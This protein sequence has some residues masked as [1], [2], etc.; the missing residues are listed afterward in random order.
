MWFEMKRRAEEAVKQEN[1]VASV[2][3]APSRHQ[4]GG[5]GTTP[6]P[7]HTTNTRIVASHT[8][9]SLCDVHLKLVVQMLCICYLGLYAWCKW[10][11]SLFYVNGQTS[12][13][14]AGIT[15][16]LQTEFRFLYKQVVGICPTSHLWYVYLQLPWLILRWGEGGLLEVQLSV[17]TESRCKSTAKLSMVDTKFGHVNPLWLL[18]MFQ[19]ALSS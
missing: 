5:A 1:S 3:G 15:R 11:Y 18:F 6:L 12:C 14:Y 2:Y 16:Y 7:A 8:G 17:S 10:W 13:N 9:W 4:G 19:I